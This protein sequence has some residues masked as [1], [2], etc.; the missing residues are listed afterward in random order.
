MSRRKRVRRTLLALIGV[1][2]LAS[3]GGTAPAASPGAGSAAASGQN[4]SDWEKETYQAALKERKVVVYGFWNPVTEKLVTDFM[5]ARY[6]V[7]Q[8]E[9]LT[10]PPATANLS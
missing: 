7:V 8:L 5:A 1:M 9:R 6:P 10:S 2:L 3:C 4:L